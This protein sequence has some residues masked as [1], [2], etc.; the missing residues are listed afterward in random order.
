MKTTIV[1]ASS[2]QWAL[3]AWWNENENHMDKLPIVAWRVIEKEQADNPSD[4]PYGVVP[5]IAGLD[6]LMSNPTKIRTSCAWQLGSGKFFD[7]D[8]GLPVTEEDWVQE[9]RQLFARS[10]ASRAL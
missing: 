2:N 10:Q 5:V 9:I 3:V 4:V 8:R 7:A 1:P 6:E